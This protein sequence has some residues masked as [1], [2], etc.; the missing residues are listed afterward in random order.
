MPS[1][2][3]SLRDLHQLH[4]RAKSLRDRLTSGPKTLAARTAAL[5]SKQV[6]L[7][8]AR[9]SLQDE[10]VAVKKHE[11]HLQSQQS[12]SD[13]LRVKLNAVKKNE[14]YKA[15]QNQLALDANHM[16]KTEGE[17]LEAMVRVDERTVQLHA[18]EL[19]VAKFADE[20]AALTKQ[21]EAHADAQKAQ[22]AELD[23]AIVEAESL[24]DEDQRDRYRRTVKQR[25][26]DAL[27]A[28]EGSA[29]SGCYVTITHQVMNELIN[30]QTLQFCM[31]CGRMLYLADDDQSTT[32]RS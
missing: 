8:E 2:A 27:A 20:V 16:G 19:E 1:A 32:G 12:K 25:G 31:A 23:R 21:I 18:A 7:E 17:I 13:D 10:K 24:I 5:A 29:C 9:K 4:Q 14:E 30:G 3:S 28:V 15:I 11:H 26:A 6:A 22:L